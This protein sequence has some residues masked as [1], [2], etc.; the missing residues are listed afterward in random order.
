MLKWQTLQVVIIILIE[1]S[2]PSHLLGG[3]AGGGGQE[4]EEPPSYLRNGAPAGGAGV[5]PEWEEPPRFDL[6]LPENITVAEGQTALLRCRVHHLGNRTVSWLR[7]DTMSI[8]SAG[9]YTYIS[10][11]RFI[12]RHLED[13]D[14]WSL[15]IRQVRSSDQGRYECQ[16]S[17]LP[18]SSYFVTLTVVEP[19]AEILGDGDIYAQAGSPLNITCVVN[20]LPQQSDD[21]RWLHE[22]QELQYDSPSRDISVFTLKGDT[23]STSLLIMKL[24]KN[25]S[26]RYQCAPVKVRPATVNV[27]V[28]EGEVTS[29]LHTEEGMSSLALPLSG[30]VIG[31]TGLLLAALLV[32]IYLSRRREEEEG[33][34]GGLAGRE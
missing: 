15:A 26:G 23:F 4:W 14:I 28:L 31:A 34:D 6:R 29:Q 13:E 7:E 19:N 1:L 18:V 9:L 11:T 10:N 5:S 20:Y 32:R 21:I 16:V 17:T 30:L 3:A 25:N 33:E 12:A 22:G 8:L 27:H 24:S 2:R